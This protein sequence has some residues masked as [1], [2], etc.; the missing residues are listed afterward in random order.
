MKAALLL[1]V[2]G[3]VW[4]QSVSGY[5]LRGARPLAGAKVW[6][7]GTDIST[8][9]GTTGFFSLPLPPTWPAFLRTDQSPDSLWVQDSTAMVRWELPQ[10][11]VLDTQFITAA[12]SSPHQSP[13][14]TLVW[15]RARLTAVP[16]CNLSEAFEGTALVDATIS[17]GALGLRQLRLLGFEPAHSPLWYES[18]PL[19]LG[20]YRPWAA[21]FLPALWVQSLKITKGIGSVL[22]GFD[23]PAGQIQVEY[24]P[25][26]PPIQP[27]AVELTLRSMGEAV[28]AGRWLH[29]PTPTR[30]LLLLGSAGWTPFQSAFLQDHNH[31]GF[32]DIP[33][34]QQ[35]QGLV[36]RFWRDTLGNMGE[37]E[38]Q[39][40]WDRRW[41]GEVAFQQP[42]QIAR[43]EAWGF[44]QEASLGQLAWRRGWTLGQGRGLSLLGQL[45]SWHHR[46]QAGF[47]AYRAFQPTGWL[48]LVYR[49]PLGDT[50]WLWQGG[51]SLQA[52]YL[53]ESLVTWHGYERRWQRPEAIPGL[54][55]ELTLT[56]SPKLSLVIGARA[57]W[58]SYWGWQLIPR[59]HLRWMYGQGGLFRLSGGRAWRLPDPLA[60]ALPFLF[61]SRQWVIDFALW[62]PIEHAWSYGVFWQQSF[63]LGPGLLQAEVNGVQALF[64]RPFLWEVEK[65]WEVRLFA[66]AQPAR[67]T[68]LYA[69]LCYEVPQLLR[70]QASYKYQAI[71]QPLALGYQLRVLLP[72][73]R[74]AL[75]ASWLTP[76]DRWQADAILSWTGP[77]RLPSTEGKP[78]PYQRPSRTP[79]YLL[80]TLQ[81]TYRQ[82]GWEL[83]LAGENL[84]NFR[85]P[86][87]VLMAEAPFSPYF[88]AALVWGPIMGRWF[89]LT[90]RYKW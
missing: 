4:G 83:Q 76:S 28:L 78:F 81:L 84:T 38:G 24:L 6:W 77:Q 87:P 33:L 11:A 2:L 85:Q 47:N 52:A 45:R 75:W 65:P 26:E 39:F 56:P 34:Y 13:A 16:C 40:L 49:Q 46:L 15:D 1:Q 25:A 44:Y 32:L 20:L 19:S 10:E 70:L 61:S 72:Q 82:K 42:D 53:A 43:L 71:W 60:E 29:Y 62:P 74:A 31:D 23:G 80:L 64:R 30:G 50:R 35:G 51:F 37:V 8:R 7:S 73:H 14:A 67:Y 88:D 68:T 79:P 89:S 18:K 48:Q 9:T 17:D 5:L 22:Y 86:F 55:S 21:H 59:F 58:H 41:G 12:A 69:E 3:W 36:K 90:W 66:G 54:F 57:D 63:L 27:R